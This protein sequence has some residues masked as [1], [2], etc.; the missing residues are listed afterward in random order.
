MEAWL[1]QKGQELSM[2]KEAR[3]HH[4]IPQCYLR[5][6]L[7]PNQKKPKLTV[8]DLQERRSYPA[9]TRNVGGVR[10]FNRI[11]VENAPHDSLESGLSGFETMAADALRFVFQKRSLTDRHTLL[12]LMN[13]I[14][15]LAIRNPQVR[16]NWS[17]SLAQ[18]YKTM[19]HMMISTKERW[20]R[21][22][23][24][25]KASGVSVDDGITYEGMRDFVRSGEYEIET[26]TE[27][28]IFYEFHGI[29]AVLPF[30]VNR[31]WSLITISDSMGSFVTC[32]RPVGV[33]WKS[34]EQIPPA[35][36]D[37]AGFGMKNTIIV[38][39]ISS[40]ML[41]T[42]EFEETDRV[43]PHDVVL[44]AT[45]ELAAHMNSQIIRFAV[46]WIYASDLSFKFIDYKTGRMKLGS[47]LFDCLKSTP[48][49]REWPDHT[50]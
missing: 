3:Q 6:F 26:P 13:L 36:R 35:M 27:T 48:P 15:L 40:H 8:L 18:V 38:F 31:L 2:G 24:G 47:D 28:H 16:N 43:F 10:D 17:H 14:A 12:V 37:S 23:R 46:R 1:S 4:Y 30:L 25:I 39:P 49:A 20:E 22:I 21:A 44:P 5:G 50:P 19:L 42:G 32:D 33:W 9:N 34:P 29:D 45:E 11:D 7:P 41:M